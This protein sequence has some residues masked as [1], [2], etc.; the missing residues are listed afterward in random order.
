M[1]EKCKILYI[2][3]E[4]LDQAVFK[5]CLKME[6]TVYDFEIAGSVSE[7]R[8]LIDTEK[9]DVIVSEFSLGDGNACDIMA[10]ESDV[11]V[12]ILTSIDDAEVARNSYKCGVNSFMIKDRDNSHLK[13][14]PVEIDKVID[15]HRTKAELMQ[16]K[17]VAETATRA[18]S[19]FLA[20]MSHELRTP[21]NA[22]I[23]FSDMLRMGISGDISEKQ[24][25][26]VEDIFASGEHLLSLINDI[27]DLSKIESGNF[28]LE[29]SRVS[30]RSLLQ[31]SM[32][33]FKSSV[34]KED[35]KLK[36]ELDADDYSI[37][38]DEKLVKQV[39][40]NLISNAVK[41]TPEGGSVVVGA[42]KFPEGENEAVSPMVEIYVKDSGIG[43]KEQDRDL[44]FEPFKQIE[45]VHTKQ[46]AGT[47]LGLALSK[48]IVEL[49][50]GKICFESEWEKGS[51]FAFTVPLK[52]S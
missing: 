18:K 28:D 36:M 42:R 37:E 9:F 43:I 23:G 1:N 4:A 14:L 30:L 29:F 20:N 24:K 49:H 47:G 22:I 27:L 46:F 52:N 13:F 51:R 10:L 21:L 26:F 25:E 45:N 33:F 50:G 34:L 15:H 12:I 17:E 16:A 3:N 40:V 38:I 7:A 8:S 2:E 48:D 6:G 39:L 41:F 32:M 35:I 11:P 5:K 44:V 19:E 31:R